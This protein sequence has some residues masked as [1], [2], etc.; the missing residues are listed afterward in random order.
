MKVFGMSTPAADEEGLGPMER[1]RHRYAKANY[2]GALVAFTEVCISRSSDPLQLCSRWD[3]L[4]ESWFTITL[5][6]SNGSQT[7]FVYAVSSSSE[8]GDSNTTIMLLF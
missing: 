3:L 2:A 5:M 8:L 6:P 7:S 1:G 4:S